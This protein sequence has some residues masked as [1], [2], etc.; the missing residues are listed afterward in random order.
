MTTD[1]GN[2]SVENRETNEKIDLDS[3]SEESNC[4]DED[5]TD[6]EDNRD[7]QLSGKKQKTKS[8]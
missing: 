2:Y 3:E 4:I 1:D 6:K 8:T 5:P 7:N